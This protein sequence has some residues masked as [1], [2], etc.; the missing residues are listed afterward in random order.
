MFRRGLLAVGTLALATIAFSQDDRTLINKSLIP[1]QAGAIDDFV[2]KGWKIEEQ[3][4]YDLDAD[5][6]TDYLLKLIEDKPAKDKDDNP[7]DHARALVIVMQNES[8][9]FTRAAVAD[10]LLQCTQCGGAFYGVGEAP[11]NVTIDKGVIVIEEDHGSRDVSD[12]TFRFR[13]DAA[14]Q[15][16]ILIGFDYSDRDRATAKVASESTNYLTGV[17]KTSKGRGAVFS[18]ITKT[19]ISI[20]DVDYQKF[21]GEASKRLGLG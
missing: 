7:I 19:K 18:T 11:A 5:G 17:R 21:E 4:K 3:L 20:D 10:K 12:L 14:S 16:F 13:Y 8:G 1:A 2:P 9:K 6:R 15:K